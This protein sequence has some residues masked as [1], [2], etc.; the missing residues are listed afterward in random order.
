METAPDIEPSQGYH[1]SQ[2]SGLQTGILLGQFENPDNTFQREEVDDEQV[3]VC[4]LHSIRL[5]LTLY[6]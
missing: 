6:V 4:A 1:V 3:L 2:M 5:V